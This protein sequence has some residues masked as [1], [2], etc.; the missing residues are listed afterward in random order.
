MRTCT[1]TVTIMSPAGRDSDFQVIHV[2][3]LREEFRALPHLDAQCAHRGR[4]LD[5]LNVVRH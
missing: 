3:G 4:V 2:A 1:Y 5:A